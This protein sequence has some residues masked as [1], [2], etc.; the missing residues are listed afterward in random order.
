MCELL[1]D[2][3]PRDS[4]FIPFPCYG[5]VSLNAATPILPVASVGHTF[6]WFE[7]LF[8]LP[9]SCLEFWSLS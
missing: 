3:L 8:L 4:D 5:R 9:S 7:I 1:G 6:V 2:G